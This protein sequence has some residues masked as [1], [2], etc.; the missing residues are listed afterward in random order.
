M[1]S[2]H[3]FSGSPLEGSQSLISEESFRRAAIAEIR[4][5]AADAD[6]NRYTLPGSSDAAA[7]AASWARR[8]T[9]QLDSTSPGQ[10]LL[11]PEQRTS[12]RPQQGSPDD[13]GGN[14][15]STAQGKKCI[16]CAT[17][18]SKLSEW[19]WLTWPS[20]LMVLAFLHFFAAP[21]NS[22]MGRFT[23]AAMAHRVG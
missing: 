23:A 16:S 11:T 8:G 5:S 3:D 2:W 14:I 20:E 7:E 22:F 21:S 4:D 19:R 1:S 9:E 10:L 17:R 12:A 18:V 6:H 13:A 15:Q